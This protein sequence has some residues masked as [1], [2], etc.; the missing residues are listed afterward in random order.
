VVWGC[1]DAEGQTGT[2]Q[3]QLEWLRSTPKSVPSVVLLIGRKDYSA[4]LNRPVVIAVAAMRM[5]QMVVY[6]VVGV[7]AV[8]HRFVPAL[9]TVLVPLDMSPAIVLRRTSRCVRGI[10]GEAMLLNTATA[11]V[12]EMPIVQVIDMAIVLDGRVPAT[13]AVLVIVTR[14]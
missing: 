4:V 14:M 1:L 5:V 7:V 10:H 9:R 13:G 6:Q 12:V 8:R 3:R 11:H 2:E